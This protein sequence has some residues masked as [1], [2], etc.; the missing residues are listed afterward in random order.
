VFRLTSNGFLTTL[1]SFNGA[2]GG[3]PQ[4]R[5]IAGRDGTLYGTTAGGG[6]GDHGTVFQ[7]TTNGVLVTLAA[8]NGTNGAAPQ[9]G[10]TFGADGALYGTTYSG[11][12][13]GQGEVFRLELPSGSPQILAQPQSVSTY[14]GRT[15]MF[16]VEVGYFGPF[17]YQWMLEGTNTLLGATNSTYTLANVQLSYQGSYSCTITSPSGSVNRSNALLVILPAPTN[18]VPI[19]VTGYNSD[20]ILERWATSPYTAWAQ[21]FD[22]GNFCFFEQG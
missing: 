5:L 17:T 22:G 3:S 8:F 10:L 16:S 1:A 6:S 21:A 18:S 15:V 14:P 7:V 4:A 13:T 11:G 2:N 19:E 9:A 12:P 20:V